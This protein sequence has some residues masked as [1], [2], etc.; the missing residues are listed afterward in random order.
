MFIAEI[1]L[2]GSIL[3]SVFVTGIDFMIALPV[4]IAG[5]GTVALFS[6]DRGLLAESSFRLPSNFPELLAQEAD[7]VGDAAAPA[8]GQ[9]GK[10]AEQATGIQAIL[11]SPFILPAGLFFIFYLTF[12]LPNR[13]KKEQERKMMSSLSKN[14]RIVTIGG[15][16]GTVVSTSPDSG[17]VTIRVDEGG[18]T[19]IKVN[20]S[21][22]ATILGDGKENRETQDKE[23][24][25]TTNDK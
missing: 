16:H 5:D 22:I 2:A 21:A 18:N 1:F 15:I 3:T 12:I 17:V 11:Q 20:R 23:T 10:P 24:A 25:L 6:A 9:P 13:R 19:R 8:E 4:S 7:P 14:D